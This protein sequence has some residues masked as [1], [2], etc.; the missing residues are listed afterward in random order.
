M[1]QTYPIISRPFLLSAPSN[2]K[3]GEARRR[4][5]IATGKDL[6]LCLSGLPCHQ[7]PAGRTQVARDV[8]RHPA[9]SR[10]T[11]SPSS[12]S[13]Q[14][15]INSLDPSHQVNPMSPA[16]LTPVYFASIQTACLGPKGGTFLHLLLHLSFSQ[17][18]H[19]SSFRE[20]C[21]LWSPPWGTRKA[22]SRNADQATVLG[23]Q[24]RKE[25]WGQLAP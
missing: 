22:R 2:K 15:P 16:P 10:C 23:A 20:F 13:H 24:Q 3:D 17:E 8:W 6:V 25:G 5:A 9:D 4:A 19:C 11:L 21:R 18:V 7:A 1:P 14:V 12:S